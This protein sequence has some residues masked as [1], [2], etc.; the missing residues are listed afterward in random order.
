MRTLRPGHFFC[1]LH[2]LDVPF[3][4]RCPF[5]IDPFLTV[6][7]RIHKGRHFVTVTEKIGT[8]ARFELVDAGERVSSDP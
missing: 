4:Y 2:G 5:C 6:T 7:A 3:V 8:V 1:Y